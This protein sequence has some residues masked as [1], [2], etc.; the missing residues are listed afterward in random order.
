MSKSKARTG[1]LP[2]ARIPEEF[3]KKLKMEA[4]ER[5]M[6]QSKLLE[7]AF[8]LYIRMLPEEV[9]AMASYIADKPKPYNYQEQIH[10]E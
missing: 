9:E 7:A 2:G 10:P 5:G 8:Y 4:D 6:S 3:Q 1:R